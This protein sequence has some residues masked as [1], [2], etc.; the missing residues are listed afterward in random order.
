MRAA[1]TSGGYNRPDFTSRT[2]GSRSASRKRQ[3]EFAWGP[4]SDHTLRHAASIEFVVS[5][6]RDGGK[7]SVYIDELVLRELPPPDRVAGAGARDGDVGAEGC[8]ARP[9]R[10]TAI[11]RASGAAIRRT[12]RQQQLDIDLGKP[13]EVGGF[14]LHWQYGEHATAWTHEESVDGK[15][16]S[17]V[18]G[19]RERLGDLD[20][21]TVCD[22]EL[23]YLR[24]KLTADEG[25]GYGLHEIEVKD[26]GWGATQNAFYQDIAK[27]VHARQPIR[28]VSSSSR[29]GRSSASTAARQRR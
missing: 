15:Q 20:L 9:R 17:S 16:W 6:G 25:R 3:I 23:R 7:G 21:F 28:A 2:T 22:T 8:A 27:R 26:A 19:L 24:L 29:T 18:R 10:W 11:R 14:V 13:R 12:G 5:S 1:R 4:T